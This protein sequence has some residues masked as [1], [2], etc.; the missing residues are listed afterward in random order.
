[1]TQREVCTSGSDTSKGSGDFV[2][3]GGLGG[4]NITSILWL[5]TIDYLIALGEG[6]TA[7]PASIWI[8]YSMEMSM[9]LS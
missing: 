8:I 1:M 4:L 2:E 7:T 9:G 3:T 6:I 5:M